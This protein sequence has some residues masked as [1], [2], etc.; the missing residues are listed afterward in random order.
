MLRGG[1]GVDDDETIVLTTP[2]ATSSNSRS[3]S[4]RVGLLRVM[5][6]SCPE[7]PFYICVCDGAARAYPAHYQWE[8]MRE[9]VNSSSLIKLEHL[10][11]I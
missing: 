7:W 3:K 11:E 9:N 5:N 1:V 4:G 6:E 8:T 2:A 10:D